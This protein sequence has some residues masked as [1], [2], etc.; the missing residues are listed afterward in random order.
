MDVVFLANIFRLHLKVKSENFHNCIFFHNCTRQNV[1]PSAC[2]YW[3]GTISLREVG[4]KFLHGGKIGYGDSYLDSV[5]RYSKVLRLHAVLHYAAAA[6]RLQTGKGPGY[7]CMIGR[8]PN[9]CLLG[10]VTGLLFCLYVKFFLPSTFI[11]IDSWNSMSLIVLDIE[12]TEKNIVKEQ[13]LFLM[14]LYKDFHFVH[15]TLINLIIRQ[16]GTQVIYMELRGVV[17]SWNMIS[18][19]LSFSTKKWWMQRYL[20]KDSK[21]VDCWPDL[22]DKM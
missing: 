14:V 15:Q 17:E 20:L 9:C 2:F 1:F 11:L 4:Q 12:I 5:L 3:H 6:V 19:L 8:G 22:L 21:S 13:G 10:H 7:C 18:S 16:H